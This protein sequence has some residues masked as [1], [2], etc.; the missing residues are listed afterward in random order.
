MLKTCP[1]LKPQRGYRSSLIR[2]RAPQADQLRL[3][4]SITARKTPAIT[5]E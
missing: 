5:G 4:R 2:H 1:T 3:R